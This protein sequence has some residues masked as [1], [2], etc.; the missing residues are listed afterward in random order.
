MISNREILKGKVSNLTRS[1]NSPAL[2]TLPI[3]CWS[4]TGIPPDD[5][6]SHVMPAATPDLK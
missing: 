2:A 6:L 4:L 1:L 5:T 3:N